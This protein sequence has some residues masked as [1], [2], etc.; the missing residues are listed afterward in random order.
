[1]HFITLQNSKIPALGFGTWKLSGPDCVR[2]VGQALDLGYRHIDTAQI[3]E[4]EA[5]VGQAIAASDIAR[6]DIFLTTKIWMSNV[7]NGDLQRSADESLKKLKTDYVD[8]LLV[9]W[10]SATVPGRGTL[11]HVV[12]GS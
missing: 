9:H 1:M 12:C 5:E 8:L 2:A 3:Y 6:N 11:V 7:R 10:P 4:N